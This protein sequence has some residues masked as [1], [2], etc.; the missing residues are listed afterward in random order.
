MLPKGRVR[1]DLVDILSDY[2]FDGRNSIP[3][4]N[5]SHFLFCVHAAFYGI[6]I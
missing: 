2:G 5:V 3:E 4:R 1:E 6:A